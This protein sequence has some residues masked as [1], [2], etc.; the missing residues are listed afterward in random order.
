MSVLNLFRPKWKHSNPSVRK[1][2]VDKLTDQVA[3][4]DV[5]KSDKDPA[6]CSAPVDKLTDPST[7]AE[8]AMSAKDTTASKAAIGKITDQ[9]L[10]TKCALHAAD[11]EVRRF[12]V[13]RLKDQQL[14][15]RIARDDGDGAVRSQALFA[16]NEK[17]LRSIA[18][19]EA[20]TE[21]QRRAQDRLDDQGEYRFEEALRS[22]KWTKE[23]DV[24]YGLAV[25][26]GY[27]SSAEYLDGSIDRERT[28]A[29][30]RSSAIKL[31]M[32]DSFFEIVQRR[33]RYGFE[34]R[35]RDAPSG[36]NR[37]PAIWGLTETFLA[38]CMQSVYS[39]NFDL[40]KLELNSNSALSKSELQS[41]ASRWIAESLT[42][43]AAQSNPPNGDANHDI[44]LAA[45]TRALV[46]KLVSDINSTFI[47]G[48]TE[49]VARGNHGD[50]TGVDAIR[51]AI[52]LRSGASVVQF[53]EPSPVIRNVAGLVDA[54]D[55]I[56]QL[57]KEHRLL[58][59]VRKT[60]QLIISFSILS[61]QAGLQRLMREIY[62]AGSEREGNA[63]QL[64]YNELQISAK[65]RS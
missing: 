55:E 3:L 12:T 46:D 30:F 31:G 32:S 47:E 24:A 38:Q 25:A 10:L 8:V 59:D 22:R 5:A 11:R 50:N 29:G 37:W 45:T 51:E 16:L 65:S 49:A 35:V 7:L 34:T 43:Q 39:R 57:A 52:R 1:A 4:A 9:A 14:L 6:V 21:F 41:Q 17:T 2:A 56:I 42:E 63:F 28:I 19:S 44:P 23:Q 61:D 13:S 60:G 26:S 36:P 40:R 58:D 62:E 53:Y 48:L 20:D 15:L 27:L 18:A 33:V 64:V 54:R